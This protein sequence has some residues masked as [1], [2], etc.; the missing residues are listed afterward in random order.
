M[1]TCFAFK[2]GATAEDPATLSIYDEIGFW[3]VQAKDF[4][5]DLGKVTAKAINLEINS[6]GGDVFAG[7]AIYNALKASGKT[8]NAKVMGV[9]A[10]AASLIAMAGDTIEMPK[11]T[12]MM[13]H[14]PWSMAIGNADELRETADTLDKIGGALEATYVA[15]TGQTP[16]KIKELLSKDTWMTAD[17]AK[18]LGFATV[19]TDDVK[20]KAAFDPARAALPA[21]VQAALDKA[22]VDPEEELTEDDP[23]VDPTLDTPIAD[24]IL[25]LAK[26]SGLEA[27]GTVFALACTD[28]DIAKARMA[29]AREIVA[30]CAIAKRPDDAKAAIAENKSVADV[31]AALIKAQATSDVHTS[32]VQQGTQQA[33]AGA[34]VKTATEIYAERNK[35]ETKTSRR[36]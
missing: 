3:G 33:S 25:A 29:T 14:N 5:S 8:I 16:A 9:A 36:N 28:L 31:R 24:S 11:N 32:N 20:A 18:E 19:V 17:E 7:I 21:N 30:L 13:V 6:P 12:F 1:R 26:A 27:H 23:L 35:R 22:A 34:G 2:A 4:I 10:S 15:K